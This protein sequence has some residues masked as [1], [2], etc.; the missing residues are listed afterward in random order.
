M[1]TEDTYLSTSLPTDD[2]PDCCLHCWIFG[3]NQALE[4]ESYSPW[5]GIVHTD[6][7]EKSLYSG[8]STFKAEDVEPRF[9]TVDC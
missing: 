3:T 2:D 9:C 6:D 7:S 4:Q 1:Q 8:L 5:L